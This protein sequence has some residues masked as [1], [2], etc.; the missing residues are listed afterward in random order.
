MRGRPYCRCIENE[1]TRR[2]AYESMLENLDTRN[3]FYHLTDI[4]SR[5]ESNHIKPLFE[6]PRGDIRNNKKEVKQ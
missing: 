4:I 2:I 1:E 5:G 6:T 3:R